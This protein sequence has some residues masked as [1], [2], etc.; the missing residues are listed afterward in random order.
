MAPKLLKRIEE[1]ANSGESLAVRLLQYRVRG[2]V[3]CSSL[4]AH[5]RAS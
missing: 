4:D 3:K 1:I 2:V 5:A